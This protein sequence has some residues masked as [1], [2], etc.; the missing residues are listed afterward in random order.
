[1]PCNLFPLWLQNKQKREGENPDTNK[2]AFRIL[3]FFSTA[4]F[5]PTRLAA[6]NYLQYI[7]FKITVKLLIILF[8][9]KVYVSC[10]SAL[11]L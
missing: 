1:M 3:S 8:R 6:T 10:N 5:P 11:K 2:N 4:C 7:S 9:A